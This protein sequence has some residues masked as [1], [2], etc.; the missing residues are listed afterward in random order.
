MNAA[1]EY[2]RGAHNDRSMRPNHLIKPLGLLVQIVVCAA[3]FTHVVHLLNEA[4]RGKG[5]RPADCVAPVNVLASEA[6]SDNPV[7]RTAG[8]ITGSYP[9][10]ICL[11]TSCFSVSITRLNHSTHN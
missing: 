1:D 11:P 2:L 6:R 4:R 3:C 8:I 9:S 10:R 7:L 5:S